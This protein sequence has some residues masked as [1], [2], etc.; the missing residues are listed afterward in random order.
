MSKITETR[1]R[2]GKFFQYVCPPVRQGS[3]PPVAA[4]LPPL[5]ALSGERKRQT[6][7]ERKAR[8]P[9]AGGRGGVG[10]RGIGSTGGVGGAAAPLPVARHGGGGGG[11]GGVPLR[12]RSPSPARARAPAPP[13]RRRK[14]QHLTPRLPRLADTAV[15][16]W[17]MSPCQN[18]EQDS[19][20]AS[21]EDDPQPTGSRALKECRLPRRQIES[22]AYFVPSQ[23]IMQVA[24]LKKAQV[25]PFLA[26]KERLE[27]QTIAKQTDKPLLD[28][29]SV[30]K[31]STDSDPGPLVKASTDAKSELETQPESESE[32]EPGPE[33]AAVRDA[34]A[35]AP[36]A[37]H[38]SGCQSQSQSH[39]SW[40]SI[41][42]ISSISSASSASQPRQSSAAARPWSR[43]GLVAGNSK[44]LKLTSTVI[45]IIPNATTESPVQP[46]RVAAA[47]CAAA[48]S[49]ME[50][51][52]RPTRQQQPQAASKKQTTAR[53]DADPLG[54][55]TNVLLMATAPHKPPVESQSRSCPSKTPQAKP[56]PRSP[57]IR[58]RT[59]TQTQNQNPPSTTPFCMALTSAISAR[60]QPQRQPQPQL[61][62]T[63]PSAPVPPPISSKI[64][65][66]NQHKVPRTAEDGIDMSYQYFVSI[67]LKRGKKAQTVRYLYR[68]MVKSLN[69]TVRRSSLKR[70]KKKKGQQ[71]A[72][73]SEEEQGPQVILVE[74]VAEPEVKEVNEFKAPALKVDRKYMPMLK[75][76]SQIPYPSETD[77]KPTPKPKSHK[78]SQHKESEADED[79]QLTQGE[80]QGDHQVA[81]ADHQD[82]QVPNPETSTSLEAGG[83]SSPKKHST[84]IRRFR[85]M[86]K[87]LV[88]FKPEATRLD[89]IAGTQISYHAPLRLM[90]RLK[91]GEA[92]KRSA[93]PDHSKQVIK[94]PMDT[95]ERIQKSV[96]FQ[97][98]DAKSSSSSSIS[99]RLTN[100][101]EHLNSFKIDEPEPEPEPA[102]VLV[103]VPVPVRDK[104]KAKKK[105]VR[106]NKT[107]TNTNKN[108]KKKATK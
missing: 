9:V 4:R 83:D 2:N 44:A 53:T 27:Q 55:P 26:K 56:R 21:E 86:R 19:D 12:R 39:D 85:P 97:L 50:T 37:G 108:R 14:L 43:T 34:A 54:E 16:E 28:P 58:V 71:A 57:V 82:R 38:I 8:R 63:P 67:P 32:P 94:K 13:P 62:H 66:M 59:Q 102:S 5:E 92:P 48:A 20:S 81:K 68:P 89:S 10:I 98:S 73:K 77:P 61:Q 36:T 7:L 40:Y 45:K 60:P 106:K 101:K 75:M 18:F 95:V 84:P 41:S 17:I 72:D 74:P 25:W 3:C 49:E 104:R 70:N 31:S 87:V 64:V 1:G 69:P 24:E 23:R 47:S 11:G 91:G 99:I 105:V 90:R 107:N 78:A 35:A 42:S 15:V 46:P 33:P 22:H 30:A 52:S 65:R 96:S 80:S 79:P 100:S 88:D 76:L 103:P 93:T 51:K 6:N 29:Q